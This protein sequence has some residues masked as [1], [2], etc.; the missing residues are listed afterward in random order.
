[1]H[2]GELDSEQLP[3]DS[4]NRLANRIVYHAKYLSE[5]AYDDLVPLLFIA[6]GDTDKSER[7]LRL[8]DFT[9]ILSRI[10]KQLF[11]EQTQS[12]ESPLIFEPTAKTEI[13]ADKQMELIQEIRAMLD[14]SEFTVFEMYFVEGIKVPEISKQ[15]RIPGPTLTKTIR[16]IKRRLTKHL[17]N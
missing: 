2:F 5:D 4:I 15:I 11:R 7:P 6:C 13:P 9:K 8:A 14:L 16:K 10:Q 3:E 12:K 1:M 17:K